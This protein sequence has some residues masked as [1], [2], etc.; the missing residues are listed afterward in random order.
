M[1]ANLVTTPKESFDHTKLSNT[2]KIKWQFIAETFVDLY[3]NYSPET[4]VGWAQ[5]EV[6]EEEYPILKW[7]NRQEFIKRGYIF[8]DGYAVQSG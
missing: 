7:F 5:K 1:D 4:A 3:E 8:K 2:E 6:E